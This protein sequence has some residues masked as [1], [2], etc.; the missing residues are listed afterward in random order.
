MFTN[1]KN[2]VITTTYPVYSFK[3]QRGKKRKIYALC[4]I[5]IQE[6]LTKRMYT[7]GYTMNTLKALASNFPC[8]CINEIITDDK[9]RSK[10]AQT[11]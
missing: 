10:Q 7:G 1:V 2:V 3:M 8:A 4:A 9:T 5:I 6:N 11:T